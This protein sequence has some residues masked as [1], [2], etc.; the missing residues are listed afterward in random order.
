[1]NLTC[2][3]LIQADKWQPAMKQRRVSAGTLRGHSPCRRLTGTQSIRNPGLLASA[4]QAS[5]VQLPSYADRSQQSISYSYGSCLAIFQ[6]S[7]AQ[8]ETA[9]LCV[10]T[11]REGGCLGDTQRC[12]QGKG[13]RSGQWHHKGTREQARPSTVEACLVVWLSALKVDIWVNFTGAH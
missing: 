13:L 9:R 1:M 7:Q 5:W 12:K 2:R 11:S 10:T 3:T 8:C 6:G 4:M